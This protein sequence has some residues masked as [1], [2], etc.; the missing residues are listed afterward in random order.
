MVCYSLRAKFRLDRF[1]LSPSVGEKPQFLPF[2]WTSASS[3]VANWQQSEKVEHGC[4]TA[5]LPLSN[6]VKI[7]SVLQRLH[8]KI[9][10][11]I[12]DVQKRETQRDRQKN[13]TYSATPA[14]GE[15]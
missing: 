12:S 13:S 4:T 3:G 14:A 10:C 9:G 15:I 1:I 5:H 11:T 6:G 2:F 8:G 7:V